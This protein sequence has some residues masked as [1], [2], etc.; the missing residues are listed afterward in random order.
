MYV[1]LPK[2]TVWLAELGDREEGAE[3]DWLITQNHLLEAT[4]IHRL[5]SVEVNST[6]DARPS[7]SESS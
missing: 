1:F 3:G 4:F 7:R 2:D 6:R 5:L